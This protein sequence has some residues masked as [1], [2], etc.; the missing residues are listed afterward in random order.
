MSLSE[1]DTSSDTDTLFYRNIILQKD[2]RFYRKDYIFDSS[3]EDEQTLKAV[4]ICIFSNDSKWNANTLKNKQ[5]DERNAF[6]TVAIPKK[7][8]KL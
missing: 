1:L 3:T 7:S 5:K 6:N 8:V 4:F 2:Y